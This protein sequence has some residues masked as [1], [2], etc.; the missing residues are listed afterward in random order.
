MGYTI[1]YSRCFIRA[2]EDG[3]DLYLPFCL[4]GASNVTVNK[5]FY[6]NGHVNYR[7]VRERDWDAFVYG[8]DMFLGTAEEIMATVT[9]CHPGT[10]SECFKFHGKWLDDKQVIS[11][12]QNGIKEAVTLEDL[13][14]QIPHF[15]LQASV[16][17]YKANEF[18]CDTFLERYLHSSSELLEWVKEARQKMAECE[19]DNKYSNVYICASSYH[20]GPINAKPILSISGPVVVRNREGQY[21]QELHYAAYDGHC[22]GFKTNQNADTAKVF[23]DVDEA[24]SLIPAIYFE[25]YYP[26][27]AEK[28]QGKSSQKYALKCKYNGTPVV[29]RSKTRTKIFFHTDTSVLWNA[30]TFASKKTAM[31]F[32][33]K[34]PASFTDPEV[35]ILDENGGEQ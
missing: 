7:E 2:V 34:L 23:Q 6:K 24:I 19:A 18:G 33:K 10:C 3:K 5:A 22:T 4:Y 27:E 30:K 28:A 13:R 31:E 29:I 12:F 25:T 21:V 1:V 14:I 15:D 11:F 16:K 20:D 35:I 9:K 17:A 8:N 32:F 26:V